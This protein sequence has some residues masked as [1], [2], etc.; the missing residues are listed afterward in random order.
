MGGGETS[1][2]TLRGNDLMGERELRALS[3]RC[4]DAYWFVGG[5]TRI[6]SNASGSAS[7]TAAPV[8][9]VVGMK[10]EEACRTLRRAGGNAYVFGKREF[11]DAS[12][13]AGHIVAQRP[14]T[15]GPEDP[16]N[17]FL[18]GA[19]PFSEHIAR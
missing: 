18:S 11:G 5:G 1:A 19:K 17:T 6:A 4:P 7:P 2:K 10:V 3:E 9:D 15:P 16:R 8:P 13:K 14:A 12:V